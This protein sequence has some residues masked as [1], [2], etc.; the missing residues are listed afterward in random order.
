[1]NSQ[2]GDLT[3]YADLDTMTLTTLP[4]TPN[5]FQHKTRL[6]KNT[7]DS[8]KPHSVDSLH[9][10]TTYDSQCPTKMQSLFLRLGTAVGAH[11]TNVYLP[12]FNKLKLQ[13]WNA[14]QQL[15]TAR[16]QSYMYQILSLSMYHSVK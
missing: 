9:P 3:V 7:S 4:H 12:H 14:H 6:F 13:N 1:M 11:V 15:V 10:K 16:Q 2:Y 8:E 5:L